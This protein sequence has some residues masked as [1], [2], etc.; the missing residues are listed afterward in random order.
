M[1]DFLNRKRGEA[2]PDFDPVNLMHQ[3][4][5]DANAFVGPAQ[6]VLL[7]WLMKLPQSI[8]PATAAK[9]VLDNTVAHCQNVPS[10]EARKLIGLLGQV[11]EHGK[12]G[13]GLIDGSRRRGGRAARVSQ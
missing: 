9:T 3:I 8:E 1:T 4:F 7:S 11:S 6:D 13:A 10:E 2:G 5:E 12:I